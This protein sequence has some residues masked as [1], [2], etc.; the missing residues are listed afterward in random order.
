MSDAFQEHARAPPHVVVDVEGRQQQFGGSSGGGGSKGSDEG[1]GGGGE[2]ETGEGAA[3]VEEH[4]H[5]WLLRC[6]GVRKGEEPDAF[7][8]L[9]EWRGLASQPLRTAAVACVFRCCMR[10]RTGRTLAHTGDFQPYSSLKATAKRYPLC[11]CQ[12]TRRPADRHLKPRRPA[13]LTPPPHRCDTSLFPAA[14]TRAL[15]PH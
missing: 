8:Q 10:S 4:T 7:H 11:S 9:G 2:A 14:Q 6:M 1:G 12:H 13:A 3:E 5:N 15:G